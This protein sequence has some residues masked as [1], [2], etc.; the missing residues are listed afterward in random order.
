MCDGLK[1]ETCFCVMLIQ[2]ITRLLI[3]L[4]E[5]DQNQSIKDFFRN[6]EEVSVDAMTLLMN[7]CSDNPPE[8][9]NSL[10]V[11]EVTALSW[12]IRSS[13]I[14]TAIVAILSRRISLEIIPRSLSCDGAAENLLSSFIWE[15]DNDSLSLSR[16]IS[17][18]AYLTSFEKILA[19][20]LEI[21]PIYCADNRTVGNW[22]CWCDEKP[23]LWDFSLDT[24]FLAYF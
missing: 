18:K 4:F 20:H 10:N 19:F 2:F 15:D 13:K 23:S 14:W 6:S 22:F 24:F 16:K 11:F 12:R 1:N 3:N 8:L 5:W 7:D 21:A 9:S 17:L